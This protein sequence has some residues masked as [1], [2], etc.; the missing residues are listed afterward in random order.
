M[1]AIAFPPA[2]PTPMTLIRGRSS[3]T[4]GRMKS[5]LM[6]S[7]SPQSGNALSL[8][9][10]SLNHPESQAKQKVNAKAKKWGEVSPERL[11]YPQAGGGSRWKPRNS[12]RSKGDLRSIRSRYSEPAHHEL[13]RTEHAPF[14]PLDR[15]HRP[16]RPLRCPPGRAEQSLTGHRRRRCKS[17][18]ARRVQGGRPAAQA[19]RNAGFLWHP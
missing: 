5:M 12:R 4:S 2:P 9:E 13:R 14:R 1:L 11:T 18:P 15:L 8:L 10:E 6:D 3:S 16:D 17:G 19:G 7:N